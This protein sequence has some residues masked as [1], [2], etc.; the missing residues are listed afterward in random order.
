[1]IRPYR[2]DDEPAVAALL[3]AAWPDDPVMV[4]IS[5]QHR[6]D[7]RDDEGR[8]WRARVAEE[9]G[10][11]V[12]AG[13]LVASARHP[14][15]LFLVV[16][17]A[18]A[19]RRRGIGSALLAELRLGGDARP[20]QARVRAGDE[21][22]AAF[23]R[24][25]GFDLLMRSRTGVVDPVEA[26]RWIALQPA[27]E[28]RRG[29]A[30]ALVARAHEDGYRAEHASWSPLSPR[31]FEE[32]LRLF[33]G[34]SWLAESALLAGDA[35]ASLHGE[36]FVVAGAELFLMWESSSGDER[37]L[38]ALAAEELRLARALG[39]RVAI[40]ADEAAAAKWRILSELPARFEPDVLLLATDAK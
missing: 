11:V 35:V 7:A 38:R 30:R 23:L 10:E 32:S 16:A 5:S 12:G 6:V 26:A 28:L 34:E 15:R 37:L 14:A 17:V 25:H 8:A 19:W 36:P 2:A 40:E 4:E 27:V 33:C 3:R 1:M 31:P 18:P 13:S 21:P 29:A 24:A 22:G 9:D 20:L 39:K